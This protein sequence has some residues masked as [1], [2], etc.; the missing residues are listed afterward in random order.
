[1]TLKTTTFVFSA[2][3]AVSAIIVVFMMRSTPYS[4]TDYG[5]TLKNWRSS[6]AD[7]LVRGKF[8]LRERSSSRNLI[9]K[10]RK[11]MSK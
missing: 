8:Q 1:V 10:K 5:F 2:P 6:L 7:T 9:D 11:V 3:L 4:W